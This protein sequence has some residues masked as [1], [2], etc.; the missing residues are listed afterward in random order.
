MFP[1]TI[2]SPSYISPARFC[3]HR[4]TFTPAL[5]QK[6]NGNAY[7]GRR[8]FPWTMSRGMSSGHIPPDI[9]PPDNS[10]YR[11]FTPPISADIYRTSPLLSA[12]GQKRAGEMSVGEIVRWEDVRRGEFVQV[13][14][15]YTTRSTRVVAEKEGDANKYS[16][17]RRW[18]WFLRP[19]IS[20]ATNT[21]LN[22][23]RSFH[24][25]QNDSLKLLSPSDTRHMWAV[26]DSQRSRIR[27][28]GRYWWNSCR[29]V[30]FIVFFLFLFFF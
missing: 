20:H 8:T 3:Q 14:M 23:A 7:F 17:I 1:R 28:C 24:T 30:L 9:F 26:A 16:M 6:L 4:S 18:R 15:S 11:Q 2:Y 27:Y 12:L 13:G 21:S 19:S 5:R 22:R 10:P 25:R 29:A